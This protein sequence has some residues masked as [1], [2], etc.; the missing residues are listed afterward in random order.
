MIYSNAVIYNK[1]VTYYYKLAKR[2]QYV[3]APILRE[4]RKRVA[5]LDIDKVGDVIDRSIID[6][7]LTAPDPSELINQKE[8]ESTRP[9]EEVNRSNDDRENANNHE[10]DATNTAL[11][12]QK[13]D[14]Q[15]LGKCNIICSYSITII[16]YIEYRKSTRES[17]RLKE[18]A[19]MQGNVS[20]SS[21][22][23]TRHSNRINAATTSMNTSRKAENKPV[24]NEKL[25]KGLLE[26]ISLTKEASSSKVINYQEIYPTIIYTCMI[27]STHSGNDLIIKT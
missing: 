24:S 18:T 22:A 17:R 9:M 13:K 2:L 11:T 4:L 23:P 8:F 10:G 20:S 25:S 5:T 14:I 27:T 6:D 26:Q 19:V 12:S 3:T 1:P 7:I 21:L 15:P 16:Y